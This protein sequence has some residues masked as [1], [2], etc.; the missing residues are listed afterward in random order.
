MEFDGV[1]SRRGFI[2]AEALIALLIFGVVF[3]ALEGSLAIVVRRFADA[4]RAD[5]ATRLAE[6]QRERSFGATCA[7]SAG[8][9][10]V[11][12]VSASWTASADSG[13]VHLVQTT[14]YPSPA[15]TSQTGYD[16]IGRCW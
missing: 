7:A 16:A 5:I 3:L 9:D 6:V 11:N 15:G 4:A 8:V 2:L 1:G 14:E 10:S 12:A 13:F